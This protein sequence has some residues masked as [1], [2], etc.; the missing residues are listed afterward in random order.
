MGSSGFWCSVVLG[1]VSC[2]GWVGRYLVGCLCLLGVRFCFA[3]FIGL[4]AI[5]FL[6][7]WVCV[8]RGWFGLACGLVWFWFLGD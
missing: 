3:A 1:C 5:D 7:L 4:H 8:L 6:V 2:G